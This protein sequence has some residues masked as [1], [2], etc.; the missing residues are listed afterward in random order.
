MA[1]LKII[2]GTFLDGIA[3]DIPDNNWVPD[4]WTKQFDLFKAMGIDTTIIIRV[5]WREQA[6]YKSDVMQ[7]TLY[8]EDDLVEQLFKEADRTGMRMYLGLYDT[9]KHWLKNDWET[10]VDINR[11]LIEELWDKYAAH[12]SFYGWYLC[13]E[14]DIKYHQ[15]KIW[16]PLALKAKSYDSTKKIMISPRYAGAKWE[17][18]FAISPELHYKQF[19]YIYNEMDGLIDTAAFMDGHVNF[20]QLEDYV[21]ATQ[22]ICAKHSI[23]FWSNLETFDRDMPWRFPP[24]AWPKLRHKLEV[25]QSHVEK[26]ITFEAPHFLSPYSMYPSALS[27]YKR[28]M[29]YIGKDTLSDC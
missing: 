16:K 14:G 24:I 4:Q 9:C 18:E 25:V 19:D 8:E 1:D 17:P 2:T 10:E 21:I 6:M 5:G 26:I 23:A 29:G 13:H 22:E 3:C 15:T 7:T 12:P 20:D 11:L 28:Y 27:L